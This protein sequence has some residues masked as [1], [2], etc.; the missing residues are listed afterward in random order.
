MTTP[1]RLTRTDRELAELRRALD[2]ALA[3]I[4]VLEQALTQDAAG[5][6]TL[7]AAG[8]LQLAAGAQLHL[9]AALVRIDAGMVEA[10]GVVK[11]DTLISNSV[12]AASYTPGAGN[13]V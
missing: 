2:A 12:V 3:R 7:Q 1:P 5:N 10:S 9:Q 11:C 13:L 6:L 8:N 4:A